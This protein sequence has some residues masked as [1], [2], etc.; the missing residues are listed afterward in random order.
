MLESQSI[1][2]ISV[3]KTILMAWPIVVTIRKL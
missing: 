3:I 2:G 1:S